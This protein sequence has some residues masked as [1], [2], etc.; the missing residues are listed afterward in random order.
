MKDRSII[1]I[2]REYGIMS[3]ASTNHLYDGKAY[4]VHLERVVDVA[5]KFLHLV[6][7][8]HRDNVIA[9][10]WLHDVIEDCR[11][12]YND[13]KEKTN[14]VVAEL[15]YA[16]TNEKGRNRK[17]RA[18]ERYY[19]GIRKTKDAT[20][21]KLCDRIANYEYNVENGNKLALMYE[22]EMDKFASVLYRDKYDDLFNYLN[23]I[24][25]VDRN[26]DAI[27]HGDVVIFCWGIIPKVGSYYK[28][29][30]IT[31]VDGIWKLGEKTSNRWTS[32]Q[33]RLVGEEEMR[34]LGVG[35]DMEFTIDD[36]GVGQYLFDNEIDELYDYNGIQEELDMRLV[37]GENGVN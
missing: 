32:N 15:V 33:V 9:A 10:C 30:K 22:R 37:F 6:P 17:E 3:H 11:V 34:K 20:F 23:S 26:G 2:A 5:N 1:D 4:S 19:G 28:L 21:I 27:K 12:T 7:E 8:G 36:N 18:N 24:G 25:R 14:V 29:H 31:M 13:I 35:L 16:V